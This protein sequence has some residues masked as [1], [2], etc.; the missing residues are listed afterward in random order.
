MLF[1]WYGASRRREAWAT[2]ASAGDIRTMLVPATC[3]GIG[4][5]TSSSP[6]RSPPADLFSTIAKLTSVS[7]PARR[8]A[9]GTPCP[10]SPAAGSF[11]VEF[12]SRRVV[13]P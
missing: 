8:A 2:C 3:R 13:F 4:G 1:G 12:V 11:L 9:W 5:C 6:M 7:R 10:L